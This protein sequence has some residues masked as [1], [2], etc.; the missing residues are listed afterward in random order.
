L[1]I[2]FIARASLH[3][4]P[5]GDTVQIL[6]TAEYL[7]K[8]NVGVDIRLANEKMNYADYD[9]LHCFNIIRPADILYHL[10]ESAKPFVVSTIY[11]DYSAFERSARKGIP[12]LL[13][14]L[15]S[16]DFAEYLKVMARSVLNG[17]KIISTDYILAGHR[18]AVKKII[19]KAAMLLPNSES[20]LRR[21]LRHY[22]GNPPSRVIPNAIDDSIFKTCEPNIRD[23][24]LV[25][26]IGRIEGRKNQLNLIRA[27]NGTHFRL[28]IIG[29]SSLNQKS[30]YAQCRREAGPNVEFI[31][32]IPQEQLINYYCKAKVHALP[33]WFETTGLSSLEAAAMGCNIVITDKGDTVEYFGED[34]FYCD[35]DSPQ[36]IR[37]AVEQAAASNEKESLMNKIFTH[38]TWRQTAKQ[39]LEA[40]QEVLKPLVK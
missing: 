11:V 18:K 16:S 31:D 17:E 20:E 35:P 6:K 37:S 1:K 7:R 3:K 9:L 12:G 29:P 32:K 22:G 28:L 34:A 10:K 19:S 5:G 38:F 36:S 30:Y 4:D 26:S 15:L 21:L 27:L 25:I 33:S 24:Q 13:F 8:I 2:L 40:Y 39:T 23:M 14:K